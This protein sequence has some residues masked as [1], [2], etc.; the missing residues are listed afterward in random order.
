MHTCILCEC[1][2]CICLVC[3]VF[4]CAVFSQYTV[5]QMAVSPGVD[6]VTQTLLQFLVAGEVESMRRSCPHG[7]GIQPSHWS[8][9]T[10]GGY[11][12]PKRVH[13]IPVAGG[14]LRL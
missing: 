6:D 4:V 13:H 11:D 14:R 8:P 10:L 12:S 1:F 3:A 9:D 2:A 5:G 7:R